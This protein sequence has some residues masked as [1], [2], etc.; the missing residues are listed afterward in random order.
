M[1]IE[2]TVSAVILASPDEIYDAW[3]QRRPYEDDGEPCSRNS[4]RG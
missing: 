3:R 1:T 4:E 2:F